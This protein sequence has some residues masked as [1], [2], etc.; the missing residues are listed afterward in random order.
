MDAAGKDSTI[1]HVMSS[2]NP[3]GVQVAFKKPSS[4]DLD[5]TFLWRIAMAVPERVGS[6]ASGQRGGS[7]RTGNRVRPAGCSGKRRH[8]PHHVG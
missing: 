2:V 1:K 4:Q 8:N 5:H 6:G 7:A 3:Q